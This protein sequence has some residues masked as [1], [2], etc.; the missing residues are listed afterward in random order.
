AVEWLKANV[1]IVL[2]DEELGE[3]FR[4]WLNSTLQI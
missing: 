2:K 4:K 3:E 1:E